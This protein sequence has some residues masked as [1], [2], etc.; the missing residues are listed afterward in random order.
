MVYYFNF[1]AYIRFFI[2]MFI[3]TNVNIS[4]DFKDTFSAYMRRVA[5]IITS[6][7]HTLSLFR[8]SKNS[9]I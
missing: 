8:T 4:I 9:L 7:K 3:E 2:K 1:S 6:N 5:F